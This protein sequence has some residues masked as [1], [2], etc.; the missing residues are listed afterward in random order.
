[1]PKNCPLNKNDSHACW[2]C[3]FSFG[4]GCI[5]NELKEEAAERQRVRDLSFDHMNATLENISFP[6]KSGDATIGEARIDSEIV[7]SISNK[8]IDEG[9]MLEQHSCWVT[10][11][12][13]NLICNNCHGNALSNPNAPDEIIPSNYCPHC[14]SNMKG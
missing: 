9:Y 12:E 2:E 3:L 6:I 13:G 10:D 5:Y 14:G 4:N 1:M 8:L 11:D 7:H